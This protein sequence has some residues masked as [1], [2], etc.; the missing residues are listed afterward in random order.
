MTNALEIAL[1]R[2]RKEAKEKTGVL[3]LGDLGLPELPPE[4]F[5]LKHLET[6][7]LGSNFYIKQ[8]ELK[9]LEGTQVL[10]GLKQLDCSRT[11]VEDLSPLS[12]LSN[13]AELD[14]SRTRIEDLS[15][16]SGLSNL[17]R[18]HCWGTGIA[19]LSPLSGLSNLAELDC[20]RTRI[21]D[22]SPVLGL[23]GLRALDC[24]SCG[25]EKFEGSFET[26]ELFYANNLVG[27]PPEVLSVNRGDNCIKSFRHY[28]VD[29]GDY[30]KKFNYEKLLIV[31]N[32]RVGKTQIYRLLRG[33]PFEEKSDSTHGIIVN[34]IQLGHDDITLNIFDFGGQDIYH[35]S[36]ALFM[37]SRS[38]VMLVWS[39]DQENLDKHS[40]E[41]LEFENFK[42]DYWLTHIREQSDLTAPVIIVQNKCDKPSDAQVFPSFSEKDLDGF[43]QLTQLTCTTKK[44]GDAYAQA[45]LNSKESLQEH[46]RDAYR[47]LKDNQGHQY[48]GPGWNKVISDILALQQNDAEF[49][50]EK[51]QHRTMGVDDFINRCRRAGN[52]NDP[53][54]LLNFMHRCGIVIYDDKLFNQKIII[55]QSWAL[56]AIY[57][58]FDRNIGQ[59][60][61]SAYSV[62]ANRGGRFDR[63]LLSSLVWRNVSVEEQKLY[64]GMM[65]SCGICFQTR[66]VLLTDDAGRYSTDKDY[67]YIAPELLSEKSKVKQELQALWDVGG[68]EAKTIELN[69]SYW[70]KGFI[71]AV[72]CRLGEKAQYTAVYWKY[73]LCAYES[74]TGSRVLVELVSTDNTSG[75]LNICCRGGRATQLLASIYKLVNEV[76]QTYRLDSEVIK[77]D[78]LVHDAD[79]ERESKLSHRVESRTLLALGESHKGE[80]EQGK[81]DTN[82][83]RFQVAP[84]SEITHEVFISYKQRDTS[85]FD[86]N[87]I[88]KLCVTLKE[89]K[90]EYRRDVEQLKIGDS[91]SN[92]MDQSTETRK[93]LILLSKEYLRSPSCMKELYTIWEYCQLYDLKLADK[94]LIYF[95]ASAEQPISLRTPADRNQFRVF[96]N[97][98]ADKNSD[99]GKLKGMSTET[100]EQIND[101]NGFARSIDQILCDIKDP[102]WPTSVEEIVEFL[103]E[104]FG[105]SE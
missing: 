96:W 22:L 85:A 69:F 31:G 2:I 9:S 33:L 45:R 56:D 70:H 75:T 61:V 44:E 37:R 52:I 18:L 64:L 87:F 98:E 60:G 47:W 92:Y 24:W 95:V 5:Q 72:I 65:V 100:F 34:Q 97:E 32:G 10:V 19:D 3:E 57:S 66:E 28:L 78:E 79:N 101:I 6:L 25:V 8:N 102:L 16:L 7:K 39:K 14:C 30:P 27:I 84:H 90:I 77:G 40:Y 13:L 68:S 62:I 93:A 49:P 54:Q 43:P 83:I 42:V 4:L 15:P 74:D 99:V 105:L 63:V 94:A 36:H 81:H 80:S 104:D 48:I 76:A 26:L 20:S 50:V 23:D 59:Q 41:G 55:D 35:G 1:R 21:E 88:N 89:N 51:R 103:K 38:I 12:G 17:A 29:L 82:K 11:R 86:R 46:L 53:K 71:R 67:E 58:V 73:G 91:I